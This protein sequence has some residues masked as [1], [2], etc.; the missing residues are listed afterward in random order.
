MSGGE[1]GPDENAT[2]KNLAWWWYQ[3]K[4]KEAVKYPNKEGSFEKAIT[5]IEQNEPAQEVPEEV[6]QNQE[7]ERNI[8][9]LE[10]TRRQQALE[11]K[12]TKERELQNLLH[13]QQKGDLESELKILRENQE[14]NLQ[15]NTNMI[16]KNLERELNT[17]D[18]KDQVVE[19]KKSLMN[20]LITMNNQSTQGMNQVPNIGIDRLTI[21][22]KLQNLVKN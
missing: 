5:T 22:R 6:E 1:Q 14:I 17:K 19:E 18:S 8:N 15:K 3:G 2:I 20:K 10:H 16:A 9:V 13:K 4:N 11:R 7:T 21:L 12:Q